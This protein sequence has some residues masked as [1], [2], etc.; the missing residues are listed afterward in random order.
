MHTFLFNKMEKYMKLTYLVQLYSKQL[1]QQAS[2]LSSQIRF[3]H[4]TQ[5]YRVFLSRFFSQ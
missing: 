1:T 4:L 2:L 3:W 5:Q